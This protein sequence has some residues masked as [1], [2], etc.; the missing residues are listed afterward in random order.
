[1]YGV[2]IT[3]MNPFV[4]WDQRLCQSHRFD[5]RYA[6]PLYDHGGSTTFTFHLWALPDGCQQSVGIEFVQDLQD[7]DQAF[8]VG[9]QEAK[10]SGSAEAFRQHMLEHQP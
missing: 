10:V 2:Y 8:A 4:K 9:M 6:S 3:A 5:H 1:M 7:P